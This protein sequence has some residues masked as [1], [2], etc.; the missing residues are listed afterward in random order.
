MVSYVLNKVLNDKL[1]SVRAA[2]TIYI[3]LL[4]NAVFS[5]FRNTSNNFK[6]NY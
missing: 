4:F 2:S 3:M 1:N 6:M 5:T